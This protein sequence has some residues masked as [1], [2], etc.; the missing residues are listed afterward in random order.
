IPGV[1][2]IRFNV[3]EDLE[4]ITEKTACVIIEP[5]QAEAGIIP[6]DPDY[7]PAMAAR[8]KEKGVLLI[9]DEIQTGF[10]RTGYFFAFQKYNVTPDILLIAKG[11]GGG[12]PVGG[13][14]SRKEVLR[15]FA[16]QPALGHITTFGGHPVCV[17]GALA[18][19]EVVSREDISCKV[20]TKEALF[21]TLLVHPFIQ[22]IRSSGPFMAVELSDEN[23]LTP[24]ITGLYKRR[25]LVDYF[26]FNQ[27]SFRIAPPLII[28]EGQIEEAC[29]VIL[30]CL[31]EVQR[32]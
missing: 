16:S 14:V 18:T 13:V 17:A 1:K 21:R 9:F 11:M 23:L 28:T 10:G 7:L 19:L 22:N 15:S 4:R 31:D 24:V 30:S 2:H 27:N 32:G 25:I 6:P 3:K 20:Q 26:L 8:C 5:V 12:M 29:S